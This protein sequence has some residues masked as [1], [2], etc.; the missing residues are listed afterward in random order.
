MREKFIT[1]FQKTH[2]GMDA[3]GCTG[4]D[5]WEIWAEGYVTGMERTI[6]LYEGKET[7]SA[8]LEGVCG[9]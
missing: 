2:P 9:L 4:K 5:E 6:E 7:P 1:W 3:D 8:K